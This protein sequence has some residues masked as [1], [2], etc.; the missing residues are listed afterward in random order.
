MIL[1]NDL[2]PNLCIVPTVCYMVITL[3]NEVSR[4]LTNS[5]AREVREE[6]IEFLDDYWVGS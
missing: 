4:K 3:G 2:G 5:L 1:D 6:V